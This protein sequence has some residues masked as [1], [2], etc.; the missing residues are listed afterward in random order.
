MGAIPLIGI[1]STRHEVAEYFGSGNRALGALISAESLQFLG[2]MTSLFACGIGSLSIVTSVGALQP[3]IT[4]LLIVAIGNFA[5]RFVNEVKEDMNR[6][7]LIQKIISFAIVI[8]GLYFI[9]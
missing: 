4:I 1:R 2:I 9:Y 7:S 8:V 3:I 6:N 5:P